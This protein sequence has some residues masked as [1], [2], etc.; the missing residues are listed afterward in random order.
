M[1]HASAIDFIWTES[2]LVRLDLWANLT[3]LG[4]ATLIAYPFCSLRSNRDA[5]TRRVAH[6]RHNCRWSLRGR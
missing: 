2:D 4:I 5:F 6:S 3:L 1:L